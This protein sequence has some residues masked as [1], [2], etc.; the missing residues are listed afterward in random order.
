MDGVFYEK[1][2]VESPDLRS[3]SG[4]HMVWD[5]PFSKGIYPNLN[6]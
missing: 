6:I 3:D 1:M 5:I 4:G 2:C